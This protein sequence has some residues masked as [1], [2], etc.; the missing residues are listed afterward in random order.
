[1]DPGRKVSFERYSSS[2]AAAVMERM[3]ELLRRNGE[4]DDVEVNDGREG[5]CG[6]N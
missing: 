3:K 5:G 6:G 4:E 2:K 1:M